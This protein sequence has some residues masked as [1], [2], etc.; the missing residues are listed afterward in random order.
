V[1]WTGLLAILFLACSATLAHA[2]PPAESVHEKPAHDREFWRAIA[3][4][5]YAVPEGQPLFPLLRELSGYLGST[6]PELRD[7][8][9]YTITAV[10]I[11][12]HKQFS[13]DELNSLL[14][15]WGANLRGGVG[16]SSR[17]G[18]LK[19]SF[20]ALCLAA[21]AERD[22]KT[23]FL[24]E[25]RYRTLLA[26]ALAYLMDE[27]DLRGFDPAIGWIHAT[28]HTADLLA[29]LAGNPLFR[30]EDERR[31]LDA[32]AGRLASAH[33]VFT[34]GEQDR[35]ALVA[36]TIARRKDLDSSAFHGWLTA[37]DA[38][39]RVWKD[40]PP[41]LELLQTFENDTYM[42]RGLAVYLCSGLAGSAAADL[43]NDVIQ[44]LQKR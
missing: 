36:A 11:K 39:Q 24:T 25:E 1:N 31:V 41:N 7:D 21:L 33:Q 27:R 43:Q 22:L 30:T 18:V 40:S 15:E 4:N 26:E 37:L 13:T 14:D 17:D 2:G 10:W 44:L 16:E 29:A 5:H 32:I 23:P 9:A 28:A 19:R 6:D 34:Y 12:H 3:K 42:L 35:L 38:D 20:S 8:L